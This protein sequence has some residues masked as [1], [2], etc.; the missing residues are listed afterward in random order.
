MINA[1]TISNNVATKIASELNLDNDKKEVIAYGTFAFFQTIFS[2]FLISVF[3]YIFN[4]LIEVLVISFT[5][6]ILRKFSGG[7]HATSPNNCAIIGTIICVGFAKMVMLLANLLTNI[8]VTLVL[9]IIIFLFSYYIIYKL[10]PVDSKSKPIEKVKKIKRLKKKS[11][12]T[13]NIYAVIILINFF[14]Y[15]KTGHKK[16]IIYSLCIYIGV[17]WQVFTLTQWGHVVVKK[18]DN[19]LNYLYI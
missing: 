1:E 17:L 2:I 14:L 5:I 19:I 16:F 4:T 8:N 6:S 11:I 12:L 9:G 10:A 3:G 7:V 13:L 15:Y 18:L